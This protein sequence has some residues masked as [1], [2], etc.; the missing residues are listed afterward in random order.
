MNSFIISRLSY[1]L[2]P[3]SVL[4][5][6]IFGESVL[7]TGYCTVTDLERIFQMEMGGKRIFCCILS[8]LGLELSFTSLRDMVFCFLW[9]SLTTVSI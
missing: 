3:Y 8:Y 1:I 5:R 9:S 7:D 4:C 6:C 2:I